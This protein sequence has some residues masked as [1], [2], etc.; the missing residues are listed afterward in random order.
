MVSVSQQITKLR[1]E[2]ATKKT[3]T[4]QSS[5]RLIGAVDIGVG[6]RL[7]REAIYHEWVEIMALVGKLD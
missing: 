6:T 2:D 7:P 5:E 1:G 4:D 3:P